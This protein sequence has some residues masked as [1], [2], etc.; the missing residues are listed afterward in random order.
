MLTTDVDQTRARLQT[1]TT[2]AASVAKHAQAT[3]TTIPAM[4]NPPDW[5]VPV[6]ADLKRAQDHARDWLRRLCPAV[7]RTMPEGLASFNE[8]FQSATGDILDVLDSTDAGDSLTPGQRTQVDSA[9]AD[10]TTAVTARAQAATALLTDVKAYFTTINGD[11]DQ[12]QKDLAT[13]SAKFADSGKW[14]QELNAVFDES[15]LDDNVLG[16]CTVIVN[17]KLAISAQLGETGA[18]PTFNT[19]VIAKAIL[20]NQIAN[21]TGAQQA[22]A[23]I[24]DTWTTYKAKVDAVVS[25]LNDAKNDSGYVAILTQ[26]DLQTAQRQWQELADFVSG[27]PTTTTQINTTFLQEADHGITT[28]N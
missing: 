4:P 9:L 27:G 18:D 26:L 22:L 12:L 10:L 16:P 8:A 13:V 14:I 1:C 6:A 2:A 3:I 17:V 15:F 11:Q 7:S 25:D 24:L 19:L 21:F 5:F 28:G 20:Q 23:D